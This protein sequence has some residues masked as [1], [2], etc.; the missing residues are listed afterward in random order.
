[1]EPASL[2]ET[3][4]LPLGQTRPCLYEYFQPEYFMR[5]VNFSNA[6]TQP[7]WAVPVQ[8][9]APWLA[10]LKNSLSRT[11]FLPTAKRLAGA[12]RKPF[13]AGTATPNAYPAFVR[14]PGEILQPCQATASRGG[15]RVVRESDPAIKP[16]CAGRMVISGRMADVC[17]ELDRMASRAAT[18]Q[19]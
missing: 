8:A 2:I 19:H 13:V 6:A 7:F 18:T 16:D 9:L 1:L 4:R 12:L 3:I 15:L 5:I 10:P 14:A 17:A 11:G